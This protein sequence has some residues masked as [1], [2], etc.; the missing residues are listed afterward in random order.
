MRKEGRRGVIDGTRLAETWWLL[1]LVDGELGF[2]VPCTCMHLCYLFD[3]PAHCGHL[4]KPCSRFAI[5]LSTC[6][7]APTLSCVAM[8]T[9]EV[10]K[11]HPK[12]SHSH[13]DQARLLVLC[14]AHH[15][16]SLWGFFGQT[17]SPTP[18]TRF[19]SCAPLPSL[20]PS[21]CAPPRKQSPMNGGDKT[22]NQLQAQFPWLPT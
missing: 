7:C 19:A 4:C 15:S 13:E 8:A 12:R 17:F 1:K 16:C 3:L 20:T 22:R 10:R 5:H 6:V 14:S 11:Q 21:L 2:M 9:S 18:S